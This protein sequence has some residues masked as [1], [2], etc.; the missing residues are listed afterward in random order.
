MLLSVCTIV[1]TQAHELSFGRVM[2]GTA[3]MLLNVCIYYQGFMEIQ[4]PFTGVI[5]ISVVCSS[6][7]LKFHCTS[8]LFGRFFNATSM[9]H[10]H[11]F[12]SFNL[13]NHID[14]F[15]GILK[16][17]LKSPNIMTAIW[18]SPPTECLPR[19]AD[20]SCHR[21]FLCNWVSLSVGEAT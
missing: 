13:H 21:E 6:L 8:L 2:F 10:R 15:H 20:S 1:C 17:P 18:C 14:P 12:P 19:N 5:E 9:T 16:N 4:F 3:K 7:M 11:F